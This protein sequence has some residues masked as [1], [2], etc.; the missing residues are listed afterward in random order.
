MEMGDLQ[1]CNQPG[2]TRL[3]D[4]FW[5]LPTRL[6]CTSSAH[7]RQVVS[8]RAV[9]RPPVGDEAELGGLR[10][11]AQ[12]PSPLS[13]PT[14]T[15]H[16]CLE[17]KSPRMAAREMGLS[18]HQPEHRQTSSPAIVCS[19]LKQPTQAQ[20]QSQTRPADTQ[21]TRTHPI[22]RQEGRGY[23]TRGTDV[24]TQLPTQVLS[25]DC[26][27]PSPG[28]GQPRTPLSERQTYASSSSAI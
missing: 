24:Q 11:L 9:A 6:A 14:P 7:P 5:P 28:P 27:D 18:C 20:T 12:V 26:P 25:F 17:G 4:L 21:P 13:M 19:R 16:K 2:Q 22:R 3:G 23:P 8:M 10:G 1:S 15:H